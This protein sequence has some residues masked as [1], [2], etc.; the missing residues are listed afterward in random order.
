[1]EDYDRE[2]ARMKQRMRE[3]THQVNEDLDRVMAMGKP[4]P[5]RED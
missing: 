5:A 3:F 1:M 4:T 2:D